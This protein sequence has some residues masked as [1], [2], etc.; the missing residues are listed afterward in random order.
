MFDIGILRRM[1]DIEVS[2]VLK[3]QSFAYNG[4][5]VENYV[6]QQLK[7]SL[8]HNPHYFKINND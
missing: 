2:E 6:L 7:P 1:C 8:L 4:F 5:L 3:E